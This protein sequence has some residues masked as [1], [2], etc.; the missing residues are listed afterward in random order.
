MA[1]MEQRVT[2]LSK[3]FLEVTALKLVQEWRD[4]TFRPE[5]GNVDSRKFSTFIGILVK[6]GYLHDL[7]GC[8]IKG[9]IYVLRHPVNGNPTFTKDSQEIKFKSLAF[10]RAVSLYLGTQAV[11]FAR[12]QIL[13]V[14]Q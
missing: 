7:Y 6:K 4:Y 1:T 14:V 13:K 10:A 11:G 8:N 2:K 9:N 3:L 5:H 12:S